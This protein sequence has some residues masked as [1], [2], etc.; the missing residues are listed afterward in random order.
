MKKAKSYK[1]EVKIKKRNVKQIATYAL[2]GLTILGIVS[3]SAVVVTKRGGNSAKEEKT[4]SIMGDSISTFAGWSNDATNTNSTIGSN[5]PRYDGKSDGLVSASQT[6]WKQTADRTGMRLLVN[7]S[8]RGTR[9]TTTSSTTSAGCMSRAV[10]LH[11]DT[12]DNAGEKPDVIAVYLGI[13]DFNAKVPCGNFE[14][15]TD[16]YDNQTREYIGSLKEFAPAYATMIHK[17]IVAYPEAEIYCFTHVPNTRR[18]DLMALEEYNN[19][20]CYIADYFEAKVVDLYNDSGITAEILDYCMSDGL[21]P[22]AEGMDLITDCFIN[23]IK[24]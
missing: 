16:I 15:L 19:V 6:W 18:D 14:N 12:G 13:N 5:E 11:D 17:M 8:W 1:K 20:I 4:L 10:N 7:N 23:A 9:V 24:E 2:I 22:N 3:G 21:H